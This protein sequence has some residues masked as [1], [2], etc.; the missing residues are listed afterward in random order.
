MKLPFQLYLAALALGSML[1]CGCAT[2]SRSVA[3]GKSAQ[4][5]AA[6]LRRANKAGLAAEV[7]LEKRVQAHAHFA[8]GLVYD[9]NEKPEQAL[10]EYWQ[11]ALA[12]PGYEPLVLE[13]ARRMVQNKKGDRAIE[14]LSKAAAEPKATGMIDAWLALAYA[15][16]GK[17]DLAIAANRTAI[18]KMPRGLVAYQNLAQ[19]Y[20]QNSRTNEALHVLDEA[21]RQSSVS[22]EFLIGLAEMFSRFGR[23]PLFSSE[24]VKPRVLAALDRAAKLD[25]KN[26]HTVAKLADGYLVAGESGKA[27]QVYL[28][29]LKEHPDFPATREKLANIYLRAGKKEQA[30]QQ[31]EAIRRENPT[32][33]QTYFFLGS[34]AVDEEKFDQAAEYFETALRLNPDQ[35]QLYYALA[36]VKLTLEK[37][38]EAL[39]CLEQARAKFKLNF[40]LEFYTGLAHIRLKKYNEGNAYIT[41]AEVVAKATD[42]GRLN[43]HFYYQV[44]S[45]YERSG[46]L[47]QAE[48]YFQKC[49]EL[50]PDY[51]A[52]MNYLG[53]MW[54]EKGMKLEQARALIEKAVQLEPKNAAFLDSMG[55]VL[56]KLNQPKEALGYLLKA[57]EH[58]EKP[59]STIYDHLGDVYAD[60]KQLDQAGEAWRKSLKVEKNEKVQKKL[61]S[62]PAGGQWRP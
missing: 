53:Y 20:V 19:L 47:E 57:I 56:F 38:E 42:P 1:C 11:S 28:Q 50:A 62:L 36:Q 58:L 27:E 16:A 43:H 14:L 51:A 31:L 26:V 13:V 2:S 59:D 39:A 24:I 10:E 60:L 5:A 9:L 49:L 15:Q 17:S 46:D 3:Q 30:S 54:A 29:L 37:P 18:K 40:M 34:L 4:P 12:N 35:E 32:D 22:A 7:A 45:A 44:G 23:L 6:K 52:A 48:K 25:P 61:D 33:P 21:A 41:S 8:T 55:W